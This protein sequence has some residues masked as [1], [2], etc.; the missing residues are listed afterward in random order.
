MTHGNLYLLRVDP[1]II[2]GADPGD[3]FII[4]NVANLIAP[5]HPDGFQHGVSAALEYAVQVLNVENIIVLGHSRCGGI[6]ALMKGTT[7]QFEFVGPWMSIAQGAKD[8][9]IRHFG[10]RPMAEQCRACGKSDSYRICIYTELFRER[11]FLS[12]D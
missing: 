11:S 3:L 8:R 2:T 4:R 7:S 12:L 6:D 1:A 9:T 5:Y 10:H